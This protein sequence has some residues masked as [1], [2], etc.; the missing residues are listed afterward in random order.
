MLQ[1]FFCGFISGAFYLFFYSFR[2]YMS[3]LFFLFF[4][5]DG[6]NP[7]NLTDPVKARLRRLAGRRWTQDGAIVIQ[8]DQ[9][10]SQNR[11]RE[12]A[13]QRLVELIARAGERPK[14]RIATRPSR[15]AKARRT[16]AKTQRGQVKRL[17][18]RPD[19]DN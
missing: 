13:L 12:D 4:L 9:F 15:A 18:S 6:L 7:P 17:R 5:E 1:G 3:T 10:R 2:I 8:A 11:N 14:P 16:D 19:T